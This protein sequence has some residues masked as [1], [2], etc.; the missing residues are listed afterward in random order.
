MKRI[1]TLL[2]L[3]PCFLFA[4]KNAFSQVVPGK[5]DTAASKNNFSLREK[6]LLGISP[7]TNPF[8]PL[9][10]NIRR[11]VEYDAK[12][13]R[14]IVKE[15]I[16]DKYVTQTQYLT[17]DEYSRLVNSEVKRGNWR[18][19][20]NAEVSDF[21]STG[22]IPKIQVN[23]K[24]FE[25]LFGGS[26][27]DIQ[28]RGEA[29]LTFLGRINKNE[30]PLFNERQR[31]QTNFDFNQ[32]IQMDLVGNIGTKLKIKSNYNTEAQFDFE[33]Q[34]KLDY[35]GG[36]DDIIKKIEAGNVSLPLNTSLITGTQALFGLKTQLQFGKL[37]VTSVYTQQKSQSRELR[38]TNGAQQNEFSISADSYEANKHYFLA[39]YFRN[40][41]NKHLANAPI[42]TSPIQIT[43]IEVWITNKA[44]NTTDSRDVLGFLNLG[45]NQPF[46]PGSIVGGG[47]ALPAGT[48]ATG[49]PQ[50]SNTLLASL[51]ADARL[52]NSNAIIPFFQGNG[53]PDQYAKLIYA[54]KLTEREFTFQPQ[55]GYI[56][57][58]NPLNADEV[59]AVAYRYTY[60]GVEYQVG[61]FST[62]VTF[63]AA[64]PKVLYAKLL[65]NETTKINLPTWDLMMK[66]I[67]SIGGYQISPLNFKL[68]IFRIDNETGVEKPIMTE[69]QNTAN[70]QWISLTEFDRLNQQN[71]KKPDGIFDFVA[72]NNAFGSYFSNNA[73][74]NNQFGSGLSPSGLASL[75]NNTNTGYITIDP[76]NGRIIFPIIEP[77]GNDLANKFLPSEQALI[78]KYTFRALYDSTQT[79]ARQL[80]QNQNRYFIKGR[81]QS[82]VSSEFSLN[83]INVPEGSVKVFA[84]TMPLQEG[85][86]YTVDYQGGRVSIINQALLTSGQPIRITTENN[87]LFGLQQRSLFGTRLDYRVNNKLNLGGT[88]MNLTEK[89]LTQKVNIGEE[90]ISNTIWGA[91]INYSSP[92]RFLTKLVDKL[93]FL[94]TKAPSN[95]TFYGEFA[96]LVPGHPRALNF[97]GSKNG[98]SYLDD[99]EASRSIIDLKSAISWQLS[100]TPQ[101][102]PE[103][104]LVND[105]A[106]GY[107]RARVAF[108]NIDPTFYNSNATTTPSN[109]RNNRNELSNHYVRQV[110][111]Q[112]VFPFKETATG[113]ALNI[114]TLDVAYYPTVRGPYNY[115]TTGFG[116]DGKLTNPKQRW[117]G[118]Q[119]KIE[120]NDFEALNVGFIEMWVLD[121]FIYNRNNQ[122][123]DV[124]FNLGNISEDILKDGR[125]SLENGLPATNDPS[126][127]DETNWGRVPKLQPVIQ[128]F[129]NDPDA[130]RAQDVGLDGLSDANE[131]AKF[132][133][134][135]NQI[136]SQ[137][138][139]TAAAEIDADPSSDNY[140]YFRGPALDQINAGILKRYEKYNGPEGN[141]K[142]SQQ[143]QEELGLENSA[144]TALPDG[145]DI[146]RD[147]NMTQ[148]D[149]YYQYKV[150]M[151]PND[152]VVGQNFITDKV[153]S[154]VRL[155][156]GNTQ[157]V[158]WYQFRIPITQYEK[159][160]GNIQ[161]FKSIRFFRMFLTNF[162]DTAIMRFAKLQLI[163]GEWREFNAKNVADQVIVDPNLPAFTP[164]NSTV[165][166][167]TVNIEENG[168]RTPIPYVT[169]PGILRE[170]DYSNYRGDTRLNEQSLAV[171]VKNLRDGY[172]RAAFKTAYS[173]F[174][175]YKHLEMFIHAE[176]INNDNLSDR[177]VSA[178][179]RIGTDN[180]DNY[181]EYVMP[182]KITTPGTSDPDA[183][184]PEANR[185]DIDLTFFQNAKLARN[186]ARQANGQPW[187][188]NVPFPYTDGDRTILVKGQ[189]D[190]S[191]VRVYM[192]G[193]RNPLR[194][195]NTL[196][197]D[198]GLDKNVVVWF[199]ELR[200]TEFDE[201]GGWAATARLN[202]KLADFADV[203]VSGSK[204]TIGF[205]SIDSKVSERNRAD[206]VLL[207]VSSAMELGKF[208]PQKS[209]VKI[210]MFVNYSKQ[211]STPQYNPRTPDIELKNALDQ[212]S[213]AQKDSILN[214]AQDYTVRRG[215]NFTNVRKERVNNAKP[216]RLWDIEN[217]AAS[218]AFTQYNHR[219]FINQSSIQNTYRASLQYSYA[220]EAKVYAPFEKI[221]KSNTLALLKDFNF[222]ILPSAIN[223]RIDVDRLYAENTL[224]NNDPNNAIPVFQNGF[225]TTFNKNFRMS[226][227]YGIAWNLTRSLQLDFNATNY[228]IIDEPDGRI[229]GMK[230]DTVWQNLKRLGRTTDYNHNLNVT[231]T[232]PI[233]KIP[234][235]NWLTVKTR[236]GTNFNWQTEP[237]STLLDPNINLGNTV[238]NSRNI[239]VNPTLNF[240]MLYNKFGF[241]RNATTSNETSGK[242]KNFFINLL[243]SVKNL[244]ANY[245]QTKGI[246][247]PGY[248]PTT[249]YFG[250]DNVTGA[251][252][253]GFAFGSQRDIRD[254]ALNNGWLTTDTLQTQLYV[255]TLRE[256]LQFTGLIEPIRDLRITIRASK[257]QT[258][259]FSS[260]FR[261]LASTNSFENLSAITTG[262][263]S[264]SYIALG[265]AFKEKNSSVVSTLFNQFMAN[266]III[267]K[268][269]GAQNP[270]SAGQNAGF[271]DGYGKESQDVLISAFMA[272]YTGKDA[273]SSK[274]NSFPRIPLPNWT[275]TYNGLTKIPFIA[276]RFS[277]VDI[278]HGYRS[279]YNINGFN[280]LLRYQESNGFSV[281]RDAN[282][283]FLPEF[284][285]AQVTVSEYFSPLIGV[286]TRFKNNL[287]ASL[288]LNR[289]RLLGLS[290]ANS[291]L[292]QLSE[293]NM[294]LGLGY[295]TN[296]FRFP[297][298]LFKSLK[299]DNNMDFKLDVAIRDNKTVIYRADLLEAEVSGGSKN[300]SLRPSVDYVLNQKFNIRLFY[301]SNIT[302]PYTS[303]TF[304]TSFSNFGF[305]LRFTLN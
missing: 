25:K 302:K 295:R 200:L 85:V 228:S 34:I 222:S 26:T 65:K 221:I 187:P 246:F 171:T 219:D 256:D 41:Y 11:V 30:N 22:I 214:F 165:E 264:I 143:S 156:N 257:A 170:R 163:R 20:S 51:P 230:R 175:S 181:Y 206:N 185:M 29:E 149:E 43:K 9:P 275:L 14:Y 157:A 279:A 69:G 232:L 139:A 62:D 21:R 215:I 119:R 227:I 108:Y 217:F 146:N 294:V 273:G 274:L 276:D 121:P 46:N 251:P 40:N 90:P 194:N 298:G 159:K 45:E 110:I 35:T 240:T 238:Q 81:Y 88:L 13:K 277:S 166:V 284:Q 250:I 102:F 84:G 233:E 207:D 179:L 133:T 109:I 289:S 168:R 100:G 24:A 59:L 281:N 226:R 74:S 173:D 60:N 151:R 82:E 68:D 135:I 154:Q 164:D 152:L 112:E 1:S 272:A 19:I 77:F 27:I 293:N 249:K 66:N 241:L 52:T 67:Y 189:P 28:P 278:R 134:A 291:Q 260:N 70:K 105:L 299:M 239:Q 79:I 15:L 2:F 118:F 204:S 93:P 212:S 244:N 97:A 216:V 271:A 235:F 300:I 305:S 210:P 57:L 123:G 114:T 75:V 104:Q 6:Q 174:R 285:F 192:M 71:E 7:S 3:I 94:S 80:F 270:N 16:G 98:V 202:L 36:P 290:L 4:T 115:T 72:A 32:R 245:V 96:Q 38:I 301:D 103:S 286:D 231:Y 111:E 205:G 101:D 218:Y 209:G 282:N 193:V 195:A 132:A 141:S 92:S 183:I 5:A 58:N 265:T 288:E 120:T 167:S 190:M 142:T 223:F 76:A 147:N 258:R 99:F 242:F 138:N 87:E 42:I 292:A 89:P 155:A 122:G 180:Q 61:E 267:S 280:S 252:G 153:T 140:S 12:N 136:K 224:R 269:L 50:Q 197:S 178:F 73:T 128:A 63:D 137:L 47:S 198:D 113:Q 213:R 95:V 148:S 37:N 297:F 261:Y 31:V 176:A 124:Y 287:T 8:Y 23:S 199:N 266:R 247:L 129:D 234:G 126:K 158:T 262:D 86:D 162:A 248:L 125:K 303:Q 150:S 259:N 131:K 17:L 127:Y 184:W 225:G 186:V 220:K 44:G 296:K 188:I 106:Y 18:S 268:R 91:D 253:L 130:R 169:P 236:Y 54:R 48:T 211:V 201:Q 56:S 208:L 55:L 145:E 116:N 255:N 107:N 78:D 304:N 160:V 161:D 144:S 203:N 191:K 182:L 83:A 254:M 33:N 64:N 177:D 53:G 10:N 196:E 172:G 263:Y 243:T 39:Q 49:F 237:L 117:G 229:D 283:N